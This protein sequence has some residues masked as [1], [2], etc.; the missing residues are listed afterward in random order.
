M[1]PVVE[2]DDIDVHESTETAECDRDTKMLPPAVTEDPA[3]D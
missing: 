1:R 3:P 2:A